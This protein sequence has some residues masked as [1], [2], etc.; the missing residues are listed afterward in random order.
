[1]N[2]HTL[3]T[4]CRVIYFAWVINFAAFVFVAIV[5]GGSAATSPAKYGHYYLDF[6][7]DFTEVSQATYTYSRVHRDGLWISIPLVMLAMIVAWRIERKEK[8]SRS[9]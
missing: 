8:N 3:K 5:L 9:D 2:P 7:G 1:M 4:V 6:R